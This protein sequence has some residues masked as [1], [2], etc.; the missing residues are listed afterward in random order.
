[1]EDDEEDDEEEGA[2]KGIPCSRCRVNSVKCS[3]CASSTFA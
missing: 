1:M 2:E 3:F